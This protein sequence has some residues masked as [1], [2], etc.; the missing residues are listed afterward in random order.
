[1]FL[2]TF[3]L[4]RKGL[5]RLAWGRRNV[6]DTTGSGAG[7]GKFLRPFLSDWYGSAVFPVFP[8]GRLNGASGFLDFGFFKNELQKTALMIIR[9]VVNGPYVVGSDLQIALPAPHRPSSVHWHHPLA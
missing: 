1:M 4:K 8:T 2:L 9:P 6:S 7:G 5:K 3:N